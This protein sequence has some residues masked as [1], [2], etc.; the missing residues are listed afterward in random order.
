MINEF[1]EFTKSQGN[2]IL[3]HIK[4]NVP[5]KPKIWYEY[6]RAERRSKRFEEQADGSI[7]VS[8]AAT[9]I[10]VMNTY[11][12]IDFIKHYMRKNKS[13]LNTDNHILKKRIKVEQQYKKYNKGVVTKVIEAMK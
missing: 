5:N 12:T 9:T 7:K 2:T 1:T 13:M 6:N 11:R 4:K 3:L 10:P 8:N